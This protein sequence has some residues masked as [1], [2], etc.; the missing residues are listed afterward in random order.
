MDCSTQIDDVPISSSAKI[1]ALYIGNVKSNKFHHPN[2]KAVKKMNKHNKKEL[3]SREDSA[4]S[5]YIPCKI[6]NP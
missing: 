4:G 2:C 6:C 1:E 5:R 3:L